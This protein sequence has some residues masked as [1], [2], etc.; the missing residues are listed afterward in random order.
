MQLINEIEDEDRSSGLAEP[1]AAAAPSRYEEGKFEKIIG[2]KSHLRM[3]SWLEKGL[4]CSTGVCRLVSD[5]CLGTG[6]RIVND[7]LIT[8]NHVIANGT[9]A[10][11]FS[12]Q[13]FFEERIDHTIKD[14]VT[15]RLDPRRFW[16]SSDLDLTI[17][18]A[19]FDAV[20]QPAISS[21]QISYEE[22]AVG[23]GV[24]IIQHPLGG[25][26]Q[27]ALTSNEIINIYDHRIQ[28]ITDTLPG[29][30]GSPVFDASW[31]VI[32]I[33]H[34]GGHLLKNAAGDRVFA[35]EGISVQ[36][37]ASVPEVQKMMSGLSAKAG[38]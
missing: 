14:V 35:N 21:L 23:D 24:S 19:N 13:F 11:K 6:F 37:L 15:V 30:S 28:Y 4:Q 22:V 26:K 33:H 31:K 7:L 12:A 18:G 20:G 27:I 10:D 36:A 17:V 34:A 16:T 1:L 25:P 38:G 3:I 9:D 8:N 2:N 5:N 32:A 29:S